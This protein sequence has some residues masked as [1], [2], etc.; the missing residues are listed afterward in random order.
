[1]IL[2]VKSH[3][4]IFVKNCNL[5][6]PA[7]GWT[8]GQIECESKE[9]PKNEEEDEE[10]AFVIFSFAPFSHFFFLCFFLCDVWPMPC[11]LTEANSLIISLSFGESC[12]LM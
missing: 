9:E 4:G 8:S 1:M 10:E 3:A 12:L 5:E 11:I 7:H 2:V 6:L